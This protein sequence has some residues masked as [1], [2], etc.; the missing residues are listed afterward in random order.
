MSTYSH[1]GTVQIAKFQQ[2]SH[3]F[4]LRYSIL[5][6]PFNIVSRKGLKFNLAL[7][8]DEKPY[9]TE[10]LLKDKSSAVLITNWTKISKGL[11]I[12]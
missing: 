12:P 7:S 9:P 10:N 6:R 5:S 8:Q 3:F 4:N 1:T 2:I 11:I